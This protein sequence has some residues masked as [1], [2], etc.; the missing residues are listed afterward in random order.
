MATRTGFHLARRRPMDLLDSG[1]GQRV[2][3]RERAD[4]RT[5][6]RQSDPCVERLTRPI[7]GRLVRDTLP[8]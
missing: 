8:N 2:D 6:P 7:M 3:D 4:D 1:S 5:D